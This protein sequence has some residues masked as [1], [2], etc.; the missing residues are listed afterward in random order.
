MWLQNP[1]RALLP[2]CLFALLTASGCAYFKN[3]Q[4]KLEEAEVALEQGDE[5]RAEKLYREVMRSKGKDSDEGRALLINLLIN[6]AGKLM[7]AERSNDGLPLYREALSLDPL[8]DESR[9]A[10]AR[11]LMKVER[12]TE[13][14]DTL[15]EGKGCRGCK[16]MISIIYLERGQAA[17]REGEYADALEDFDMALS[18]NRDPLTVLHKI[19]V[20]LE[21]QYGTGMDAVGYLDH[22]LRLMPPDQVGVQQVWW[23]KRTG[24]IYVAALQHED[25]AI[26]AAL[27]LEDPRRDVEP[28][29]KILDKLNLRMYAASLQIYAKDYDQGIERGLQ[30]YADAEGAI[31]D[32]DLTALRETLLGLF[33][34][35]A[36]IHLAADE[37]GAARRVLAQ[38]LEIEPENPTLNY[39]NVIAIAARSTSNA[40]KMLDKWEGEEIHGRLRALIELIYVRKMIEIGQFT[41]AR[42]GLERAERYGGE[43]LLD[44][45]LARAELEAETRFEGLRKVW[46]ER[47]REIDAF[48]YPQ[49]RV[50][51]YGRALAYL[52]YVQSKYDDAAARDYLRMP[53]F[54]TRL[55]KLDETISKF[56]P[57]E[58]ELL[59]PDQAEKVI[60]VLEREESGE[61][62]VK[63]EGPRKQ[64]VVKVPGES[65]AQVELA[66]PGLAVLDAP[67]GLKPVFAEPGVKIIVKI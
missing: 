23:D 58:A 3:S 35:R 6:R 57:Y 27:N 56:Y 31:P 19:D 15:M 11:A 21:G 61:L 2:V 33:M 39:Q 32:D 30:T 62:E 46:Y 8:R 66:E 52:R 53:A 55:E 9:I 43:D 24:L 26:N 50:N 34:Q 49:G 18:M 28:A 59:P 20:Y 65:Q 38:G 25:A 7:E 42:T 54:Q 44:T 60:L 4:S 47:Y 36:A 22:A 16:T 12:Y 40:R 63:I 51:Y 29:Q 64:H 45:R 41:A 1:G 14:I 17:V 67:G 13:A 37:D 5:A 10:Y 48:S